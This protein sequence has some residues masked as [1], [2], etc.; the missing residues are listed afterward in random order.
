M[1]RLTLIAAVGKN[2]E[3]GNN[4]ELIWQIP[5]DMQ[6]FK[7]NTMNKHIIM[8]MNTFKSLPKLLP[9]R[10]HIVLTHQNVD[11]NPNVT[12]FYSLE[13]LLNYV[14]N[15]DEEIV[16][17]GGGQIYSL[18]INYASKILLTEIDDK[19]E[20]DVFFPEFDK[21][22]WTKQVLS[23]HSYMG[24]HYKHVVYTKNYSL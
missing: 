6:F 19:K 14:K 7:E 1:G 20:A 5:E 13:D 23:E 21:Q 17:I 18:L 12:V 4:N 16:V 24:I 22:L 2:G 8:G 15:L 11:L 10:K 9:N 3:L